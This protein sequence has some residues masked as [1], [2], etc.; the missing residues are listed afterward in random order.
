[1]TQ[2]GTTFKLERIDYSQSLLFNNLGKSI[3]RFVTLNIKNNILYLLM[4]V[5]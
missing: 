1:L 5:M 4:H 3:F 2:F